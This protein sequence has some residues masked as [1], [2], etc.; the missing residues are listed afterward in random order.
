MVEHTAE[1]AARLSNEKL[2]DTLVARS[3]AEGSFA[4]YFTWSPQ[5]SEDTAEMEVL[6][7]ELLRRLP[8]EMAQAA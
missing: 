6:K 7:A 2:I 3:R 5:K 4:Y 1:T 8:V